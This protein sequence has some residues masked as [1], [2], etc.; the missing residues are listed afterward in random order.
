MSLFSSSK[1]ILIMSDDG[2]QIYSVGA[3][4]VTYID[5]VPWDLDRFVF[6]VSQ[7]II[8][9]AKRQ[10]TIILNDM[11]EQHYRKERIPNVS[12]L[13]QKNVIQRRLSIAFPNHK[14]SAA[15]KLKNRTFE[16]KGRKGS[17]YLFASIPSSSAYQLTMQAVEM[18]GA[19]VEGLYL[20]PVEASVVVKNLSAKLSKKDR[21]KTTWTVFAGQHHNGGLRQIV[22]RDG[23]LAL[24]RMTPIVDTDIEPDLWAKEVAG[25][26][27]A[28]MSYLA[29][30]GYKEAD[31]LRIIVIANQAAAKTLEAL[32]RNN[33]ELNIMTSAKAASLLGVRVGK[34]ADGRYADPLH[35]A[36]LKKLSK[37]QLPMKSAAV[38]RLSMPRKVASL[39]LLGLLVVC[40]Y[41]G[42]SSFQSF[43]ES[44]TISDKLVVAKQQKETLQQEYERELQIKK[45]MGF[46]F[47]LVDGSLK[48][49]DEMQKQKIKPLP[50][51]REIGRSLGADIHLDRLSVKL[52]QEVKQNKD[53]YSN[54]SDENEINYFVDMVLGF[55]F[56]NT[57]N[58]DLGV[59]RVN[60]LKDRLV[61]NLPSSY[62]VTI[63]RQVADLSYTGNFVG[64]AQETEKEQDYIA[65]L[66]I[67][68][69]VQ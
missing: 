40:A 64:G 6:S 30:F 14:I 9:E 45:E 17:P 42:Y 18:S 12:F 58:P 8:K 20:L 3:F 27:A 54:S 68:G 23:E 7:S 11:V 67:R 44:A 51:M 31:G 59:E 48:A 24:T 37:F 39:I 63:S 65:E 16:D 38:T 41:L 61:Q 60:N 43:K 4:G 25:E 35:L 21:Q 2:L 56:P 49:F 10:P 32:N 55:S 15:L 66:M 33:N 46:D 28:T 1:C 34:Q 5:S 62:S 19:P 53:D 47:A 22:T 13:D 36:Y 57:I 69:P 50:I 26:L 52:D 29:R